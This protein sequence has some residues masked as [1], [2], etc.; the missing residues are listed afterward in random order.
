MQAQNQR[1][2]VC[3]ASHG[4]CVALTGLAFQKELK[5]MEKLSTERT[6]DR[7]EQK[8]SDLET[9]VRKF[10]SLIDKLE[11]HHSALQTKLAEREQEV[12]DHKDQIA[13]LDKEKDSLKAQVD[14]QEFR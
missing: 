13:Q 6:A 12:S 14:A 11:E 5:D 1:L 8:R 10:E 4:L 9:D 2:E 7:L 3:S